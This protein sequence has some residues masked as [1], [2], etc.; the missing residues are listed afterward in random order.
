MVNQRDK[1]IYLYW[2]DINISKFTYE[3]KE[4]EAFQ[5]EKLYRSGKSFVEDNIRDKKSIG[6]QIK[7]FNHFIEEI[8]YRKINKL[9]IRRSDHQIVLQSIMALLVLK[10]YDEDDLLW[11]PPKYR[12]RSIPKGRTK[13]IK[14][15]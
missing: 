1:W 10:Q 15:N 9:A 3:T 8:Y 13:S 4:S 6:L 14:T 2:K 12:K 7:V 5:R 11:F